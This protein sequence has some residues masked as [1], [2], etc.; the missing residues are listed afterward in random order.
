MTKSSTERELEAM[1]ALYGAERSKDCLAQAGKLWDRY[2]DVADACL[3]ECWR[4]AMIASAKLGQRGEAVV[5][6]SRSTSAFARSECRNG[7]A[8]AM[9][10]DYFM[11]IDVF[12]DSPEIALAVLDAIAA[13]IGGPDDP[14]TSDLARGVVLE[15]RGFLRTKLG[16]TQQSQQFLDD[17]RCDYDKA[18]SVTVDQRRRLKIRAART[19]T[20]FLL[21]TTREQ[22]RGVIAELEG[23][24]AEAENTGSA[25]AEV[26]RVGKENLGRML[27][28][29]TDLEPY[30]VL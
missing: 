20:D 29:R 3:G 16:A 7:V 19:S 13:T 24:I 23:L 4:F 30:E 11:I 10:P 28:G 17:A 18:L 5:W 6:R 12:P 21:A 27:S 26:V 15:K 22:R 8:L 9:L 2:G 25:A 1:R 14:V